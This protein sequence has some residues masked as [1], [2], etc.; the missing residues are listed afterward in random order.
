MMGVTT[1]KM[2]IHFHPCVGSSDN[3][4][5]PLPNNN[6]IISSTVDDKK[7]IR[8][9][10]LAVYKKNGFIKKTHIDSEKKKKERFV[11]CLLTH[12]IVMN[13]DNEGLAGL[14]KQARLSS[15]F[16]SVARTS[17]YFRSMQQQYLHSRP[18]DT[19]KTRHTTRTTPF[20]TD[21]VFLLVQLIK[22]KTSMEIM[23]LTFVI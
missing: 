17:Q 2:S 11:C 10:S 21:T 9:K 1:P 14:A 6:T 7:I 3:C 13:D 18:C 4:Q 19:H 23:L 20:D 22:K 12:F 8:R 5:P 15:S 16:I